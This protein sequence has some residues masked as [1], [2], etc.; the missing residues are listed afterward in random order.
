LIEV[1]LVPSEFVQQVWHEVAPQLARCVARSG[2]RISLQSI[3]EDLRQGAQ[4]LWVAL[5]DGQIIGCTTIRIIEYPTG[6]RALSYEN[7]AGERFADWM[8]VGHSVCQEYA[9]ALG[10]TLLEVTGRSGWER[11]LASLG[12]KRKAVQL[13]MKIED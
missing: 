5:E 3:N 4:T 1:S 9:K 7:L 10:C 2:G 8:L 6:V 13:S 11:Y 12:Y